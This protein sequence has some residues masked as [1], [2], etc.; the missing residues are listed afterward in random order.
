DRHAQPKG[1]IGIKILRH[2]L[3]QLDPRGD[4]EDID[5]PGR[6]VL[7]P[8]ADH[9]NAVADVDGPPEEVIRLAVVGQELPN[10]RAA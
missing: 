5:R 7:L 10:V 2:E 8:R 1:A 9:G 6:I 3:V 4:I